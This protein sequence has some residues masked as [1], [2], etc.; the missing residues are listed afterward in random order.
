MDE[1][2]IRREKTA[3][4]CKL[5]TQDDEGVVLYDIEYDRHVTR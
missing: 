5:M 4:Y 2:G 3:K 1:M